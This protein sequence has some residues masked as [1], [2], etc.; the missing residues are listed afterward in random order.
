MSAGNAVFFHTK[1]VSESKIV[2]KML[3]FIIETA[4]GGYEGRRC[5]MVVAIMLAYDRLRSPIVGSVLYWEVP[6][7]VV[8][9]WLWVVDLWRYA[10][11]K[12]I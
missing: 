5:E 2:C 3:C 6:S 8:L 11:R 1:V 7:Q 12:C 9:R 10:R 4:V